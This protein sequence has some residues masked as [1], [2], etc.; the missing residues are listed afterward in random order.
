MLFLF[1]PSLAATLSVSTSGPYTTI[2]SAIAAA[3]SGDTITVAAGTWSECIDFSGKD[4]AIEGAGIGTTTLAGGGSCTN[5]V[6]VDSG[7]TASLS[8]LTIT[9]T[10]MRAV[11]V[12]RSTLELDTVEVTDAGSTSLIGAGVYVSE[13]AVTAL[14]S[15]FELLRASSGGGIYATNASDLTI[16]GCT[17]AGNSAS[18]YGGGVYIAEA[19]GTIV[20]S[21]SVFTDNSATEGA[22]IN[23]D[24]AGSGGL[25]VSGTTFSGGT[26][27]YGA[28]I[29]VSA[30][31]PLAVSDSVFTDN[32]STYAGGAVYAASSG[33]LTLSGVEF[34]SNT[35]S[36]YGGAV[37]GQSA[38]DVTVDT[39]TFEA[40]E[41]GRGGGLYLLGASAAYTFALSDTSFRSNVSTL[42]DGGAAY[43]FTYTVSVSRSSFIENE[44]TQGGALSSAASAPFTASAN[45]FCGNVS[46]GDGGAA[47]ISNSTTETWLN[48]L[49]IDNDATSRGGALASSSPT[50]YVRN[51]SFVGNA[52]ANGGA[53]MLWT[54]SADLRDNVFAEG[55]AG[56]ALYTSRSTYASGTTMA[57]DGW[58]ANTDGNA[59]GYLTV[60]T[61]TSGHV[62]ADPLFESHSADG[63][64]D[65]DNL[66]LQA[67]SPLIDAGEIGRA[68]V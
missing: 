33:S 21:D 31:Y 1:S 66:A 46:S 45:L 61:A 55:P 51:N 20:V 65:N 43:L 29:A 58:Y 60:D 37:F 13:G 52:A 27:T 9:N 8:G 17:F 62:A 16:D 23:L 50:L 3:S 10:G 53:I 30:G 5:A 19:A 26:A 34:Q 47:M 25:S 41:A 11:Y 6:T 59:G 32:V 57:Y 54:N 64:C 28:A 56:V 4:L 14:D 44:S 7:E 2:G 22:A 42:G 12:S 39:C 49:F 68:H 24:T 48:N 38:L 35:A 15:S 67:G 63:D 36:Q 40:N 18:I